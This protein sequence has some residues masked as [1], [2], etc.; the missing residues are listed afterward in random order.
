MNDLSREW[1]LNTPLDVVHSSV[2]NRPYLSVFLRKRAA[3]S[4]VRKFVNFSGK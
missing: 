1:K 3:L 4:A 2:A